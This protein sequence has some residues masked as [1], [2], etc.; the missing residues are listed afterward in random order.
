MNRLARLLALGAVLAAGGVAAPE[1]P[2]KA[3]EYSET[4][5]VSLDPSHGSGRANDERMVL[6]LLEGLTRL[7]PATGRAV[8]AAAER[9]EV[10]ADGRTWTFRLRKGATWSDGSPV[11]SKDFV[12]AWRRA[13]APETAEARSPSRH[14]FRP[15]EGVARIADADFARGVLNEASRRLKEL[16]A[17]NPGGIPGDQVQA[18]RYESGVRAV[19]ATIKDAAFQRFLRWGDDKFPVEQ[20]EKVLKALKDERQRLKPLWSDT[21]DQFGTTVGVAAPD[22]ATLVVKTEGWAPYLP[23]LVA[24]AAFAPL[25]PKTENVKPL[26]LDPQDNVWNGPFVL[27]ARGAQQREG[28]TTPSVVHLE[29]NPAYRGPSPAKVPAVKC[30]TDEGIDEELR[31]MKSG[32][33]QW[34]AD[35]SAERAKDVERLPGYATRPSGSVL[36]LR[37]RCDDKPFEKIEARRAFALSVDRAALAKLLWPA[38]EPAER[39]VPPG[40]QGCP[41]GVRGP[42]SDA[43]AAKAALGATGWTTDNFPWVEVFFAGVPGHGEVSRALAKQWSKIL[44]V[45]PGQHFDEPENAQKT[46]REG[47]YQA[48]VSELKGAVDDPS[49]FLEMFHSTNA[50]GGLGWRDEAFDRLVDAA[51]NLDAFLAAP[52]PVLGAAKDATLKAKADAAKAGGAKARSDLRLALLGEAER[53]L[54]DQYVIVPL[55]FPKRAEVVGDVKG[56]GSEAAWKNPTFFGSLVHATR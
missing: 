47:V 13:I 2:G 21:F 38:G 44:G 42:G 40:V 1:D 50:D 26:G 35:P 9:W 39:I 37:F 33:S 49:A 3:F 51:R 54:L 19:A 16:A 55:C 27:R 5:Y 36:F 25:S 52:D 4:G 22:D 7:D 32:E 45:E 34:L 8:P 56:L 6:A 24:R 23:E 10:A 28:K 29:R 43:A 48:Y 18:V 46:L 20:A 53:R 41:A 17:A 31:R 15:I 12:Y 11:T 14:L 30:W